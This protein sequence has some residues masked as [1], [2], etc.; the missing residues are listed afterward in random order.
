MAKS[1]RPPLMGDELLENWSRTRGPLLD[2]PR[3]AVCRIF[4]VLAAQAV[5]EQC[6][7]QGVRVRA[8]RVLEEALS[9]VPDSNRPASREAHARTSA[10]L[11]DARRLMRRHHDPETLARDLARLFLGG[12]DDGLES[13][14]CLAWAELLAAV[15]R[16][17]SADVQLRAARTLIARTRDAARQVGRKR[18]AANEQHAEENSRKGDAAARKNPAARPGGSGK[19]NPPMPPPSSG[20]ARPPAPAYACSGTSPP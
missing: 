15:A 3:A 2:D 11:V 4:A 19:E 16:A 13:L 14:R 7:E 5:C 18:P 8:A 10:L 20:D 17:R 9:E 6:P 1:D 12:R